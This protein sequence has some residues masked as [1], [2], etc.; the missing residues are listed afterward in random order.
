MPMTYDPPVITDFDTARLG[1]AGGNHS[2]DVMPGGFRAPEVIAGIDWDFKVDIR[3][4]VLMVRVER[5]R[6]I[7]P[8]Y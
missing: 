6:D 7:R 4:V 8:R 3:S 2:G 5:V 1:L